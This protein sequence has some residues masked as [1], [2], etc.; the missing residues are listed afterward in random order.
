MLYFNFIEA[1][2]VSNR[3]YWQSNADGEWASASATAKSTSRE[4]PP[5]SACESNAAR[6]AA[7]RQLRRRHQR[8]TSTSTTRRLDASL[9]RQ[10]AA[11]RRRGLCPICRQRRVR[12]GGRQAAVRLWPRRCFS[13]SCTCLYVCLFFVFVFQF[14]QRLCFLEELFSNLRLYCHFLIGLCKSN[15]IQK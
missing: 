10:L 15:F 3:N 6:A 5:A 12:V 1:D 13:V 4:A 7:A 2:E 14:E 11:A 8:A 9:Q